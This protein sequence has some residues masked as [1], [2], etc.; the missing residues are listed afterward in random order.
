MVVGLWFAVLMGAVTLVGW[1]LWWWNDV[2]YGRLV[3]ATLGE[4][5]KLPPGHMGFP[6]IG[7]LLQF[8]WYFKFFRRPD[9]YIGS[10]RKK[11]GDGV[12]IIRTHLFGKPSVIVFLPTTCK[13]VFRDDKSFI[14][15]WKN[16]EIVGET[17]LVAVHGKAHFRIRSFVSR[18]INKPD[19]LSRIALAVQPRMISALQS[20]VKKHK[21]V[22][23][24]EVKKVTF[25]NIGKY[26]ASLE[27]RRTLDELEECFAGMVKGFRAYKLNIPGTAFHHALQCRKRSMLIFKDE[28]EKRK[29][30]HARSSRPINDL[31]DGLMNLKDDE[32]YYLSDTEI[33]DNIVSLLVSGFETT[34]LVTTWAIYY[35]AKYPKVLQKLRDENMSLKNNKNGQLVTS[36]EILKSK[37]TIKVVE[38]TIRLANVVPFVLRTATKNVSYKGYTIPKGWNMIMWYLHTNTENF[39]DP[40]CFNPDRWDA[41]KKPVTYQ[42]F[43]GGIR[44]C[45]GNMLARLQVALIL[46][47]LS[48]GYKWGLENPDAKMRYLP[49]PMLE[50]LVEITIENL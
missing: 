2:R 14:L 21:V 33:L 38:E 5:K 24:K 42:P 6:I 40:M 48:T 44:H 18:S 8:L 32:V 31:L 30:I 46:H 12:G 39:D 3:M 15:I 45:V 20:W 16:I 13:H 49:Y 47:H 11:Y 9:D 36:D 1:L 22:A 27:P 19:A 41:P 34:V 26:F 4:G 29:K 37:Y 50:D 10:K 28:L 35:L 7:D 17:S 43:G 23:Y 25:Q